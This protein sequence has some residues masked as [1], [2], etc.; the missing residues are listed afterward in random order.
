MTSADFFFSFSF[1]LYYGFLE[2]F[3]VKLIICLNGNGYQKFL[4]QLVFFLIDYFLFH[5]LSLSKALN[6]NI[7]HINGSFNYIIILLL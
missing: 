1:F 2:L 6:L 7:G 5:F 3:Y 4:I